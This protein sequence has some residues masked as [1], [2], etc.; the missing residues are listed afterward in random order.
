VSGSRGGALRVIAGELAGRRFDAPPGPATRPTADR[1]RQATFNALESLGGVEDARV[2]DAFAGSGALGIEALSRGAARATF[3]DTDRAAAEAVVRNLRSLGLERRAD[4][5]RTPAA[6]V[7]L[8]GPWDLVLLDPPY[9]YDRWPELLAAVAAQLAPEA[10]VVIES[11]HEVPLPAE[12]ACV[13]SKAYGGTVVQFAALAG[14]S[15]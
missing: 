1:V 12:L 2:L 11:D 8:D 10:L 13:R 4:V 14:A 3:A 7:L 6:S 5:R 15:S 9:A